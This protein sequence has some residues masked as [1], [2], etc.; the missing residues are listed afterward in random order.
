MDVTWNDPSPCFIF[1]AL[2]FEDFIHRQ[3]LIGG[4]TALS[5]FRMDIRY[6]SDEALL[7]TKFAFAI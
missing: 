2:K 4:L 6:T 7:V 5:H 3:K 1:L